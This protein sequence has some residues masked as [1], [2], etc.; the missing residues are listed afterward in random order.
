M[1]VDKT[2]KTVTFTHRQ[3]GIGIGGLT[4]FFAILHFLNGNYASKADVNELKA[5]NREIKMIVK[6]GFAGEKADLFAHS[7]DEQHKHER[8]MDILRGEIK[9]EKTDRIRDI[10]MVENLIRTK[11][12]KAN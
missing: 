6:D 7:T 8:M 12:T 9:D 1:E 10:G 2:R 11:Q 3:F 4:T 5:Q